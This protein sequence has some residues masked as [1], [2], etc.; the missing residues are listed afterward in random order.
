MQ[1][2]KTIP[3]MFEDQG[4]EIRVLYDN[5]TIAAVPSFLFSTHPGKQL[6]PDPGRHRAL[7][8]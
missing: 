7:P 8:D 2:H 6:R 1:L 3:I 5:A 4:Y